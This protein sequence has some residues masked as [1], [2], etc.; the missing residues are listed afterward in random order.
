MVG[1]PTKAAGATSEKLTLRPPEARGTLFGEVSRGVSPGQ[2]DGELGDLLR[3]SRAVAARVAPWGCVE[4]RV[5]GDIPRRGGTRRDPTR[6]TIEFATAVSDGSSS[7]LSYFPGVPRRPAAPASPPPKPS[8][9]NP[10][11]SSVF[12]GSF[13]HPVSFIFHPYGPS[14]RCR[15]FPETI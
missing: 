9:F 5:Q 4:T 15:L 3:E 12:Y 7:P 1:R 8:I 6:R 11:P 2:G 10:F 14:R 13:F